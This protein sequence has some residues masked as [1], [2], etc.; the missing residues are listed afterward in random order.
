[1]NFT[2]F[3][4]QL[5]ELYSENMTEYEEDDS[6][7]LGYILKDLDEF[8]LFMSV[9]EAGTLDSIQLRRKIYISE[10]ITESEYIDMQ[11]FFVDYSKKNKVFDPFSLGNAIELDGNLTIDTIFNKTLKMN[12]T[13]SIVTSDSEEI[14]TGRIILLDINKLVIS[15]LNYETIELDSKE[16]V[17]LNNIICIDIINTEN[18][19]YDKFMEHA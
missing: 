13:I 5:V 14:L 6:F 11:S 10:V 1:M 17:S 18:F 12:K 9:S 2:S 15:L 4:N 19:L 3:G 7:S 8:I 16:T